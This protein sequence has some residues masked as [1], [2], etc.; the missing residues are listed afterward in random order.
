MAPW[1]AGVWASVP[2]DDDEVP[3]QPDPEFDFYGSC[4]ITGRRAARCRSN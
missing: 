2:F 1:I 4:T 3:G